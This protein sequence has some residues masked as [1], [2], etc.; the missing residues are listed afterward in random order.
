MHDKETRSQSVIDNL[1]TYHNLIEAEKKLT[2]KEWMKMKV[3]EYQGP[4]IEAGKLNWTNIDRILVCN[5]L[6]VGSNFSH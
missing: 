2:A 3:F 1:V 4:Y 5:L 6:Q